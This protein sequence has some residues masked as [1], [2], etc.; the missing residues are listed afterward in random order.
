VPQSQLSTARQRR[1]PRG[2][3]SCPCPLGRQ[4]QLQAAALTLPVFPWAP[5]TRPSLRLLAASGPAA[6]VRVD[7]SE[8]E[9][10]SN[11]GAATA[12][13][14]DVACL[15]FPV[16][17]A[18][19]AVGTVGA[20]G[21]GGSALSQWCTRTAPSG[22]SAGTTSSSSRGPVLMSAGAGADSSSRYTNGLGAGAAAAAAAAE[23]VE[24]GECRQHASF[25]CAE[26]G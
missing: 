25:P 23:E 2:H 16:T 3:P 4:Q 1:V 8:A 19:A 24:G 15:E 18:L 12:T 17:H 22:N 26:S 21:V 13:S 7:T 5:P 6:S 14:Q 9:G 20:V 10:L 11:L